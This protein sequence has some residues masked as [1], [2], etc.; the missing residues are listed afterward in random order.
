MGACERIALVGVAPS[1]GDQ[2]VSYPADV[3][4]LHLYY[5]ASALGNNTNENPMSQHPSVC[6]FVDHHI[7]CRVVFFSMVKVFPEPILSVS[8]EPDF[9]CYVRCIPLY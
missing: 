1:V 4:H 3:I 8:G 2:D 7:F 9:S 6:A 5:T